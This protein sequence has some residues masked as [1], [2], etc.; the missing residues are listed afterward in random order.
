MKEIRAPIGPQKS[1]LTMQWPQKSKFNQSQTYPI[2]QNV[3]RLK[4][5]PDQEEGQEIAQT[6]SIDTILRPRR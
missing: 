6:I 5:E 1:S 2:Q 3:K 4:D